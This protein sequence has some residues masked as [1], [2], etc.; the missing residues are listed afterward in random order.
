MAEMWNSVELWITQQAFW[1]Q[2]VVVIAV[3]LPLCLVAASLI[4]RFVDY[5]SAAL[6][7]LRRSKRAG[8]AGAQD[9]IDE[10]SAMAR[11]P[12]SS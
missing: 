10:D 1:L 2:F 5:I 12:R 11:G 7:P 3:L 6:R 9:G 4:D 8:G